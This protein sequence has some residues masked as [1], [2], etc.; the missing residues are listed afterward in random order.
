[1]NASI[2]NVIKSTEMPIYVAT[3][4]K[5]FMML[6]ELMYTITNNIWCLPTD[7]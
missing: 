2:G 7:T 6:E 1:M 4:Y 5:S 3:A